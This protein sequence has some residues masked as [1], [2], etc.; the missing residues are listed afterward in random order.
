LLSCLFL[1]GFGV[2]DMLIDDGY[3]MRVFVTAAQKHSWASRL[4]FFFLARGVCFIPSPLSLIVCTFTVA[5]STYLSIL[6][7]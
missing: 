5:G 4:L 7:L 1:F 6:E 3:D 2:F